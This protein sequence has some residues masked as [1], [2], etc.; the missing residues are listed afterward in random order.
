METI[1]TDKLQRA[2][3]SAAARL[4]RLPIGSFQKRIMWL[5]AYVFFFE[6]GDL[7]NFAF[8]APELQKLWKLSINTIGFITSAAFIGMFLGAI[9]G[10][11]FADKVGRKKALILTTL[12]F[13]IFSVLNACAWNVP[14]LFVTRFFTGV[15]LAAMTI[16]AITYISE[17]FPAKKRGTCQAWVMTIGLVGIPISAFVAGELIP[18]AAWGW[19]MVFVWG[20]LGMFIFLFSGKLVESPLWYENQ[21]RLADADKVLDRIESGSIAEFGPSLP[22]PKHRSPRVRVVNL[23]TCSQGPTWRE[24]SC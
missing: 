14:G 21:G 17:M 24:R 8:A 19:R 1:S 20:A 22:L 9:A 16:A 13:S 12:F 11:W 7:N 3:H 18:K 10:G 6:L 23:R 2:R 5:T 15:G 4:D